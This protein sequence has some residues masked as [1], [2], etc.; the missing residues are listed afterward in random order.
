MIISNSTMHCMKWL[1]D[2][3]TADLGD[4]CRW[5]WTSSRSG[6]ATVRT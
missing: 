3:P 6:T 5:T 4:D 1:M 2:F